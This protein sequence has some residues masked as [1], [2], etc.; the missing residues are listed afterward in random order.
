[1]KKKI[2]LISSSFEEVSLISSGIDPKLEIKYS[3]DANYPLG[4]SYLE[5]YLV[6]RG[7]QALTLM[8][9]TCSFEECFKKT[10]K[11]IEDFAP[12]LIG[13]QMLTQ[14][15]VSTYRLIEH[16]H[17][18]HPG[19]KIIIGGIHA[20]IMHRQIIEKY[21][22]LIVVLG[23]G[24]LTLAELAEKLPLD[25]KELEGVPGI[26]FSRAGAVLETAPR[27]L[28]NDLDALPF[29]NHE[30][31][32]SEQRTCASI[33]TSRG[34]PFACS[35]CC[36][37]SISQRKVRSRSIPNV[38][39]E[40]EWLLRKNPQI[41]TIWIQDDGFLINNQ[42]AV[43]FCNEVIRRKLKVNFVCSGRVKPI[44]SE[45]VKKLEE[46]NFQKVLFGM[47]SGDNSILKRCHKE[48]TQEDVLRAFQLFKRSKIELQAFVILGLPGEDEQTVAETIRF[49]KK[50]QK[51]KY[52]YYPNVSILTIYPGTEVYQIA[53]NA[54]IIDDQYWLTDQ[55]TP[56]FTLENSREHLFAFKEKVLNNIS[57]DRV[58]TPAGL[59]AQFFMIPA[60]ISYIFQYRNFNIIKGAVSKFFRA[61]LSP[62]AY[63]SLKM[64]YTRLK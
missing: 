28:I 56:I 63:D 11:L 26:A 8:S 22:F 33:I 1:M 55:T 6:S 41:T 18:Q 31:F 23:E 27:G 38:I 54:G 10:V 2:L 53:K 39:A 19:I 57:S 51:I 15:R 20:T 34:C 14:N 25:N 40:I 61:F 60:I 59:R 7:H 3:E 32:F 50:L 5:S 9:N 35:F 43:E 36:L 64:A 47:E 24:E 46:A 17:Q 4:L 37:N 42:R 58:F 30:I 29:P 16:I 48:I 52:M 44:S 45:V 21:P 13:L 49:V 12:D 62:R